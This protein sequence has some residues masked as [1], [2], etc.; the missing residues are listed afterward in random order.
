MNE[1]LLVALVTLLTTIVAGFLG[2]FL[3]GRTWRTQTEHAIYK[4]RLEE[5][6]QFLD[7][8]SNQVGK[9]FFLLQ[10]LYWAIE[11]GDPERIVAGEK[12]YF[13]AV[14]EWNSCFWRNRNKIRLL[15]N[16]D[17]ANQF[18]DYRDD[19]RGLNPHSLHYKFVVAHRTVMDAKTSGILL[20]A[21]AQVTELNWKCSV[22]LEL[23]TTEFLRRVTD[24]KLLQLPSTP[25]G[26]E[27][28]ASSRG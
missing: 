2:Y 23:L 22:F 14:L 10:R 19:Q 16:E 3:S 18:L 21:A 13:A 26:A 9:R 15:V 25:G 20:G 11:A 8:L 4:A 27:Q 1:R 24:L 17:Q 7:D 5:G 12:E 6:T 28:A